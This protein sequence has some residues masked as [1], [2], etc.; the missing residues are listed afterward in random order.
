MDRIDL[1]PAAR[2]TRRRLRQ[3]VRAWIMVNGV[4]ASLAALFILVCV[5]RGRAIGSEQTQIQLAEAEAQL[6]LADQRVTAVKADHAGLNRELQANRAVVDQPDWGAALALVTALR[7]ERIV[8]RWIGLT[9]MA[10][11]QA[12]DRTDR[13]AE[14][15]TP[16]DWM[17]L[18]LHGVAIDQDVV[19]QFLIALEKSGGFDQ[20]RLVNT[21]PEQVNGHHATRFRIACELRG[22]QGG[23]S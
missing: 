18:E 10:A 1:I 23:G 3:M 14:V 5:I 17:Q 20:V 12:D 11:R 19:S 6:A 9:P 21:T 4:A 7:D 22:N 2:H 13:K 15:G 16:V 8:L